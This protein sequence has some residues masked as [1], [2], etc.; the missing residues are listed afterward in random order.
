[1]KT[2]LVKIFVLFALSLT[3]IGCGK[4]KET[5]T[6]VPVNVIQLKKR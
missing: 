2:T 3:L 1:M 6:D 4:G 5:P